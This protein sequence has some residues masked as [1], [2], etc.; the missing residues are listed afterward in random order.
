MEDGPPEQDQTIPTPDCFI[1]GRRCYVRLEYLRRYHPA[2]RAV[3]NVM[4]TY[5]SQ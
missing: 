1:M 3:W 4:E 5:L 2:H